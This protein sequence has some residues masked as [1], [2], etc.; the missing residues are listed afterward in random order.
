[1]I[2]SVLD[3]IIIVGYLAG[4]ATIGLFMKRYVRGVEDYA[5]AGRNVG[6]NLGVASMTCTG[7][8][9]VT[10]MY[11]AEM[12]FRYGFAG[13]VPGIIFCFAYLLIGGT[14]FMIGPMRKARVITIPELLERR[15]GKGVRWLAGLVTVLGGLLNMGI[16]LR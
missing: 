3:W 9:I 12:G 4:C 13:A 11:T 15:F 1:M 5:V 14:G 8:G 7:L 10:V 2:L 6:T 16:F